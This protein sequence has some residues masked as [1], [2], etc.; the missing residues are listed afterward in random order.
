MLSALQHLPNTPAHT[1]NLYTQKVSHVFTLQRTTD[2][3]KLFFV[4]T[5]NNVTS[6]Q[7]QCHINYIDT[8]AGAL[9]PGS[10]FFSHTYHIIKGE[11]CTLCHN[12]SV[13]GHHGTAVIVD[14]VSITAPLVGIQ[15]DTSTL[16]QHQQHTERS[17]DFSNTCTENI[18]CYDSIPSH[19][20]DTTLPSSE[21]CF[22]LSVQLQ[23][24]NKW[25]QNQH[26]VSW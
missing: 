10:R 11:L 20:C 17:A 18:G 19:V 1:G 6:H 12:V 23:I 5:Y 3:A 16:E 9:W 13:D 2:L 15:V 14:P 25:N 22:A 8:F 21:L 24:S 7:H 4:H 26:K